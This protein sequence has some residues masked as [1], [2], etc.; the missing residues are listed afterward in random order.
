MARRPRQPEH[1]GLNGLCKNTHIYI[2]I[3]IYIDADAWIPEVD[4]AKHGRR[5]SL[6]TSPLDSWGGGVRKQL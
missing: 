1:F 6:E 3:H 5:T 2:Y 4:P